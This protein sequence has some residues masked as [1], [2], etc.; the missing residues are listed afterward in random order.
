M[1]I[2]CAFPETVQAPTHDERQSH[3]MG[4]VPQVFDTQ[5]SV[6]AP[7]ATCMQSIPAGQLGPPTVLTEQAEAAH[8]VVCTSNVPSG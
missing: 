8:D 3:P 7:P 1:S 2:P 5:V 4:P 6:T